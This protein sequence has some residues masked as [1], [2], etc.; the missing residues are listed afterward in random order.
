MLCFAH[1]QAQPSITVLQL[2]SSAH[3]CTSHVP[4]EYA[5]ALTLRGSRG[6]RRC[7]RL[8]PLLSVGK[9]VED[10]RSRKSRHGESRA[11]DGNP[12][13]LRS[14][15]LHP[16]SWA[17][18][19]SIREQPRRKDPGYRVHRPLLLILRIAFFG[20]HG[21]SFLVISPYNRSADRWPL[22]GLVSVVLR[23]PLIRR[24]HIQGVSVCHRFCLL[25]KCP[26]ETPLA[27]SNCATHHA[28]RPNKSDQSAQERCP[29]N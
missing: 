1:G 2:S 29:S 13:S 20:V 14:G 3:D 7:R 24:H 4:H 8:A 23:G 18:P 17:C 10:W 26:R 19:C 12:F 9:S 22:V 25:P 16:R 15:V 6:C 5:S 21:V 27:Y 11:P 28:S